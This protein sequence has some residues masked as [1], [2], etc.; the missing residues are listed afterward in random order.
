M[1]SSRALSWDQRSSIPSSITWIVR[2]SCQGGTKL[3][4]TIDTT[5]GGN[6]ILR[7]LENLEKSAHKNLM[8]FNK[9]K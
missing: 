9:T 5:E 1:V 3:H 6:A 4:G 7:D 2:L 8:R